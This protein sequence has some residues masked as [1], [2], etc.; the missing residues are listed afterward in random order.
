MVPRALLVLSFFLFTWAPPPAAARDA[1]IGVNRVNL[2]QLPVPERERIIRQMV[3]NGVRVAR[4]NIV[5][6]T[7]SGLETLRIARE[8]GLA[9]VLNIGVLAPEYLRQGATERPATRRFTARPKLSDLV[10]KGTG[11]LRPICLLYTS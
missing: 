2:N 6:P 8:N 7:E 11:K 5:R 9:L 3:A 10:D 1:I 4:I